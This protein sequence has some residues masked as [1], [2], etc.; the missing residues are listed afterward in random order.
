[1][2]AIGAA[3]SFRKHLRIFGCY[4]RLNLASALE[5]RASFAI[6]AFGMALSNSSFIFFWWIAFRQVGGSIA[7]YSFE[8][9]L[10][11]WAASSGG[12]GLSTILFANASNL[13]NLIITGELDAFLLQPCSVLMNLICAKTSLYAYGDAMYGIILM[14]L[15]YAGDSAAWLWFGYG[16]LLFAAIY[17]AITLT[18][19]TLT[20]YMGDAGSI[21]ALASQFSLNFSIYPESIYGPAVRALMYSLIPAAI[22]VH[23]PL[24]LFR[25]LLHPAAALSALGGAIAYCAAACAFFYRGLRRYESGNVIVTKM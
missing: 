15:F 22:A 23:V 6:Q 25:E 5:Y 18:A 14:A 16:V 8:D 3:R 10:F 2:N 11:I 20:F 9:V 21:G 1:M 19:H 7:G 12:F 13:S 4:Y 17:A 24:K